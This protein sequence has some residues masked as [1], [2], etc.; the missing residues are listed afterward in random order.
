MDG[1]KH[2]VLAKTWC[3]HGHVQT[4]HAHKQVQEIN[5]VILNIILY[6]DYITGKRGI[7]TQGLYQLSHAFG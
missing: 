3:T 5:S 2:G 4:H 1:T 6:A 7:P